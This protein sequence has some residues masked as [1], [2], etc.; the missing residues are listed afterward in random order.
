VA[1]ESYL[2]DCAFNRGVHGAGRIAQLALG[3][4]DYGVVGPVTR[5]AMAEREREPLALLTGLRAA[6]E[7]YERRV[8]G[9]DERSMF[10]LGLVNRWD[11]ALAVAQGFLPPAESAK[12]AGGTAA[13]APPEAESVPA[14]VRALRWGSRGEAVRAWQRFISGCG[15]PVGRAD[16]IFG[17]KTHAGT[18][19]FQQANG[20][21]A[22][23]V[24]GRRTLRK[25]MALGFEPPEEPA[26]DAG[27]A[28]YPPPPGFTYGK[29]RVSR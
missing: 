28:T 22:D 3:V 23:G 24:A 17:D 7:R 14:A 11:K 13:F 16:G 6:R 21:A 10:W 19:A 29:T 18:V 8:V 4:P 9:R 2:R 27:G 15:F 20:L 12:A 26:E 5:Q 1:V 25:A